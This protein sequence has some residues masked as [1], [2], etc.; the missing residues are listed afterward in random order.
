[1][2]KRIKSNLYMKS[3]LVRKDRE[4]RLESDPQGFLFSEGR[5]PTKILPSD[6]PEWYVHGY[7]YKR[8]GYISAKGV[9]HL[10]YLP[11]Y[12]FENHLHK[13]DLLLISYKDEIDPYQTESGTAWY[14]G[15]N[16][17]I[18]GSLIV[19]FVEIVGKFSDYNVREIQTEIERKQA[20]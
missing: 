8:H 2:S 13:D 14:K 19:S 3:K 16:Y 12:T 9:K 17:V 15:Y 5:Y 7:M 20:W 6:L 18:Y 1:M 4:L 11:N 10:L